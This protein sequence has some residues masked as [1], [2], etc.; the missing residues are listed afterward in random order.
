MDDSYLQGD[1]D[2]ICLKNVNDTIIILRSLGFNIH[3]KKSGS[4]PTQNL[5]YLCFNINS[6]DMTLKLTED[7]KNV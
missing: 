3:S 2:E 7:K 1:S 6:K 4:K 5:I